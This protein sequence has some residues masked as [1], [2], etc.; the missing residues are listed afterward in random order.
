MF[1]AEAHSKYMIQAAEKAKGSLFEAYV[2]GVYYSFLMPR[3]DDPSP[4]S[5]VPSPESEGSEG[6]GETIKLGS[7]GSGTPTPDGGSSACDQH[8]ES[9][10]EVPS[11]IETDRAKEGGLSTAESSQAKSTD[12]EAQPSSDADPTIKSDEDYTSVDQDIARNE[13]TVPSRIKTKGFGELAKVG[14][15]ELF[16]HGLKSLPA[17]KSKE[18]GINKAKD[19]DVKSPPKNEEPTST[20]KAQVNTPTTPNLPTSSAP[21]I[22]QDL[23]PPSHS[24][25]HGQAFDHLCTWL[26]PLFTPIAQFLSSY[27][28]SE[29]S[30]HL[31]D[32][33]SHP[34][35]N[36]TQ[37][38]PQEWKVEDLKAQGAIGALNQFLG[39]TYGCGYLPTWITKKRV[40]DVWRMV[41]IVKTPEGREL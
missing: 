38:V 17:V 15:D 13:D 26:W 23:T 19:E 6:T 11:R 40:M 22:Q 37:N 33:V 29:S 27:L 1:I 18:E 2:A 20:T 3:G 7:G 28:E 31:V 12:P 8:V 39:K 34:N 41:A 21:S 35:P 30:L 14:L 4:T 10:E 16:S 9:A 36:Q 5:E 25:T 24:R 32:L